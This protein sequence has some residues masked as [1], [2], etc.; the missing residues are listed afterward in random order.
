MSKHNI[1]IVDDE[2]NVLRSLV[3]L[4]GREPYEV[5][6][7]TSGPEAL[8]SLKKFPIDLI[9]SDHRMPGMTGAEFLRHAKQIVPDAVRIMLTG[10]ADID[11]ATLAINEGGIAR[12]LTKPWEG[13][14]VK[15][16]IR[17][18]LDQYDLCRENQRLNQLVKHQNE[19]RRQ[20]NEGLEKKVQERTQEIQAALS[21]IESLNTELERSFF[22]AMQVFVEL[23]SLYD[24]YSAAHAKRVL[25]LIQTVGPLFISDKEQL[26]TLELAALLHDIGKLGIPKSIL[27]KEMSVMTEAE[28]KMIRKHPVLGEMVLKTIKSLDKAAPIIRHHHEAF[29]G[30]G[31]PDGLKGREAPLGARI[32]AVCDFYDHKLYRKNVAHKNYQK[33]ALLA[34]KQ[35]TGT[36]LDGEVV[37]ILTF[38]LE[39]QEAEQQIR[40]VDVLELNEYMTLVDDLFSVRGILLLKRDTALSQQHI[41]RILRFH[42]HDP[43]RKK[44]QVYERKRS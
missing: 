15:S 37:Q 30:S 12:F 21:R 3:R 5:H 35:N 32:I 17:Q 44:I 41:D 8:E 11:A 6:V 34:L 22:E 13:N 23:T 29:N 7:S 9:I 25:S 4:L 40:E 24:P 26:Q 27:S 19:E 20:L 18:L 16:A 42:R 28:K 1:L 14:E 2:E 10:Y 43:I 31:Y 39:G 36:L 38:Y 33:E